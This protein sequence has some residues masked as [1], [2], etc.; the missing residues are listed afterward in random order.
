MSLNALLSIMPLP[1]C[2]A[3]L[4]TTFIYGI[5]LQLCVLSVCELSS[6]SSNANH[7]DNP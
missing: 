3:H 1:S 7:L 4:L 5:Y 2:F 6:W